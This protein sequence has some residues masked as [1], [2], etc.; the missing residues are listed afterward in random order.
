MNVILKNTWTKAHGFMTGVLQGIV[1][2]L[3]VVTGFCLAGAVL[4][5][6]FPE[7]RQA[8]LHLFNAC[9]G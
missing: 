1:A 5:A 3:M 6:L 8:L 2:A 7:L 9:F 4:V